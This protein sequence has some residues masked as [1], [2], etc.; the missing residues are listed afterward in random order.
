L[1]E[2]AGTISICYHQ[3]KKMNERH[4]SVGE[5]M[6]NQPAQRLMSH[7]LQAKIPSTV[8]SNLEVL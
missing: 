8:E 4:T 2:V 3:R 5:A 6:K 1:T 7:S